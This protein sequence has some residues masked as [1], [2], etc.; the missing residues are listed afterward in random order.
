MPNTA[1]TVNIDIGEARNIHP[2]NKQDVGKRL[3][4]A[5][6]NICYG[7]KDLE[8]S[9][10]LLESIAVSGDKVA[11]KFSHA[12]GGL[13]A[14]GGGKLKG[15]AIAGSDGKYFWADAEIKGDSV[16]VSS[17]KVKEPVSVR[18]AWADDPECNLVNGDGLPAS[19]F[20]AGK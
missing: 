20:Q 1:M 12:K 15:F 6:R 17:D 4:L 3:A 7:E 18:Y 2:L 9:G 13:S 16:S 8:Y 10:P 19:P 11:V 14:K 5:A